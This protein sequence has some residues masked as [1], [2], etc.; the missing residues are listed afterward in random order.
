MAKAAKV[1]KVVNV[2]SFNGGRQAVDRL[3][4]LGVNS[5][6]LISY[7]V[8]RSFTG[9]KIEAHF[10]PYSLAKDR[11]MDGALSTHDGEIKIKAHYLPKTIFSSGDNLNEAY[12][13]FCAQ[14]PIDNLY[15]F[16]RRS[17]INFDD[18][19]EKNTFEVSGVNSSAELM[20]AKGFE[21]S[22]YYNGDDPV[23]HVL[24]AERIKQPLILSREI[25]N[26]IADGTISKNSD[27]SHLLK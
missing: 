21:T 19:V 18:S 27:L 17:S 12:D 24:T 25:L 14:V 16:S 11:L 13:S 20:T 8:P 9:A 23:H 1:G 3:E 2:R 26:L 10:L 15:S 22:V 4:E 6:Y 5:D 7:V